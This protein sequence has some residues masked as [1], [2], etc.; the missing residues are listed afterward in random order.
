M[1][2]AIAEYKKANPQWKED[3]KDTNAQSNSNAR[4]GEQLDAEDMTVAGNASHANS[5]QQP[6]ICN[7]LKC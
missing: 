6:G 2:R 3:L 7:M 4:S 1:K 5:Q